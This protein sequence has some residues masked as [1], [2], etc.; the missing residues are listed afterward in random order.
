M[1]DLTLDIGG[2]IY[3][4]SSDAA[5]LVYDDCSFD[6]IF[7]LCPNLKYLVISYW[8]VQKLSTNAVITGALLECLTIKDCTEDLTALQSVY[9]LL[10]SSKRLYLEFN[11]DKRNQV[12]QNVTIG[13]RRA[14]L[15]ELQLDG[16]M[17][18]DT[19]REEY[20]DYPCN[21][22]LYIKVST[23]AA[24]G[25]AIHK[26]CKFDQQWLTYPSNETPN[27]FVDCTKEE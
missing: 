26:Y 10:P 16:L 20:S 7:L 24:S 12:I 5:R 14:P 18:I 3:N 4:N 9:D 17:A 27:L 8:L 15:E 22:Q 25:K 11:M 23:I 2:R 13:M 19:R 21:R 1:D 6:K